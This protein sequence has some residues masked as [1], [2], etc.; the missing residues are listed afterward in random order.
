[1]VTDRKIKSKNKLKLILAATLLF[2]FHGSFSQSINVSPFTLDVEGGVNI[3]IGEFKDYA[4][5]G[6]QVGLMLNKEVYK[7]LG[8]GV[9]ANY[10]RFGIKD[11]FESPNNSWSNTSFGIGPQYTLPI[12]M[13]FIQLYGHI[14]MSLIKTPGITKDAENIPDYFEKFDEGFFNTLKIEN[15][16]TTALH[17]DI[18]IKLGAQI[19]SKVRLFIG[20]SY[21]TNLNSPVKYNAR[22]ISKAFHPS[23]EVEVDMIRSTPFEEKSLAFSSFNVNAGISINLGKTSAVRHAQD[24]NS[25][26]SNKPRP[27][28][29]IVTVNDTVPKP[30][31]DYNSSRSNRP[32]PIAWTDLATGNDTVPK[33]LYAQDYNSSRSNKPRPIVNI[34]TVDDTVPKPAQDYNSS[35]SNRPKPIRV[36]EDIEDINNEEDG[37]VIV[38]K[39]IKITPNS[40][41]FELI[42]K[43]K[44]KIIGQIQSKITDKEIKQLKRKFE[45][46]KSMVYVNIKRIQLEKGKVSVSYELLKI[47]KHNKR[48]KFKF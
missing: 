29:N 37:V 10:N 27:I 26:R 14:G 7:N 13:L 9:S 43:N 18:G 44:R 22:D 25:S 32:T 17:T 38:G 21:N 41:S 5:N 23:G 2:I 45:N 47:Q 28:V 3:P 36:I 11:N 19:S 24:Y 20:S 12:N 31:Q 8:L 42:D 34:V 30:A 35:R 48:K 40:R 15:E 4:N 46:K 16:N 6:Y 39:L 1:M 33:P